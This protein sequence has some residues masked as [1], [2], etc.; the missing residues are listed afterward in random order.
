MNNTLIDNTESLKMVDTLKWCISDED[1]KEIKIATGYW[2]IPGL[3]L[4]A[5]ELKKFLE[6]KGTSLKLLIGTDPVVKAYL[7]RE[8]KYKSERFPEDFIKT[9]IGE[10]QVTDDYVSS[11]K[12]LQE[13]CKED[14]ATSK[15][16]IRIYRRDDNGDAQFLHAK[17]Y[18]FLGGNT[19]GIIG[20]SNFTQ[21]GLE[22]NA[23]LNHLECNSAMVTSEPSEYNPQ[24][25]HNCWFEE[26]WALSQP[27]NKTFLEEV[28]KGSTVEKEATK[29]QADAPLTPYELY[30]KLLTYKFGDIVDLDQQQIIKSYLPKQYNALEYQMQAVKQCFGIMQEHGGFMLADVV[31]LG[32]TIV[33]TLIIKHFLRLPADDG[34]ERNVLIITPPAIQSAWRDTITRFDRDDDTH[35]IEPFVDY[36]TTG[37]IGKLSDD[38]GEQEDEADTG[39]FSTELNYKNYGL[40]VIDES[41]KF[42]NSQTVMYHA[43]DDLIAQIGANTGVYPYIGLLS[44]TPQNNRPSD[45]QN[46]IYLFQRNHSDSTLKKAN[47]G[48]LEGFFAEVNR[49]YA[50]LITA[51]KDANG[52]PITETD[53][54]REARRQTLKKLSQTIR[55]CVLEDILVRRTRTDIMKHYPNSGLKFPKI[56]GPH[57]LEYIMDDELSQLFTDTMTVIA[58]SVE[59]KLS[60]CDYLE[61]YRYRAIEYFAGSAN[62]NKYKGRGNRDTKTVADQLA[63]IMQILLVKRLESSFAAFSKSLLNLCRYTTNMIRMWEN[64]TIFVCPQINVNDELDYEAKTKKRG[65]KISFSEC[66]DDI[67]AKIKKLDDDGRNEKGQ[68]AEYKRSDFKP[69]YITLLK[70]DYELISSLYDRWAMNTADPK[71]DRFKEALSSELFDK[72]NNPSGKLVIFSE[73]IDTVKALERAVKAKGKTVLVITAANRKDMEEVI[74]A[75]FDAN[76][77]GEQR[78]DYQVIITTEVLAEGVNLHCANTILNYDTPWNSTRLMQRIGRVNRIGSKAEFVYVYNFMPSAQGNAQIQLVRKAYTKLQSFHTLFG[79]DNQ[80]FTDQEEVMHY[81]LNTQVNGG[82]SPMEKYIAELKAYK[83]ANPVRFSQIVDRE[84]GLEMALPTDEGKS[85]FLVRNQRVSSMFV[86][87]DSEMKACILSGVDMYREFRPQQDDVACPLPDD[88]EERKKKAL[89]TV[90]QALTRMNIHVRKSEKATKAKEIITRMKDTLSLSPKSRALLASAFNL[91]N[92]GNFDIIKKIIALDEELASSSRGL[93][94]MTQEEVDRVL[95][96]EIKNI[97]SHVQQRYGKAE[98]YMALSK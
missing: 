8:K 83:E 23:E 35:K 87:V 28:L 25:G 31:G 73:A 72:S 84:T 51:P 21:K 71:Y 4:V 24:K 54:Q 45:L 74:A 12:L 93:F 57:G 60:G 85:Y 30:I 3:T 27:W 14:E 88:W 50:A 63:R 18:I 81:D 56:S 80:V 52:N 67:R 33:G 62:G 98:V 64:D 13:Y 43:L 61:Y 10:L 1:C 42:R 38:D 91:V 29:Q 70:K 86:C 44:A 53:E 19:C 11:V 22:G 47:G 48:N 36:V 96:Q 17:C 39:D 6:S 65:R 32:K 95:E 78:N 59:D 55:D 69:E 75:N 66:V 94:A 34:R 40:I 76:Y 90:N 46:Q 89:L 68:N 7:Q 26:K 77:E 9:S 97:V 92:K 37:S 41:H 82:E 49:Q 79:E 58:P 15:I 20:S 16:K 2:D 5:Q